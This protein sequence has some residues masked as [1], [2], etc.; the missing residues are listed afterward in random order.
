MAVEITRSE[1]LPCLPRD[2]PGM[3]GATFKGCRYKMMQRPHM[4]ALSLPDRDGHYFQTSRKTM[5]L[6]PKLLVSSIYQVKKSN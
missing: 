5:P 1:G 3:M 4:P 2:F 6:C